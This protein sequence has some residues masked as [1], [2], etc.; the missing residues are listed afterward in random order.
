[1]MGSEATAQ[2]LGNGDLLNC[3]L[4]CI[5]D[6]CRSDDCANS[7]HEYPSKDADDPCVHDQMLARFLSVSKQWF[8][9]AVPYHW[10]EA[11][12]TKLCVLIQASRE[13]GVSDMLQFNFRNPPT[14]NVGHLSVCNTIDS[15]KVAALFGVRA[16]DNHEWLPERAVLSPRVRR[17]FTT[18]DRAAW[19][20]STWR[21]HPTQC[22]HHAI[23][24]S[25][26]QHA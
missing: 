23:R 25:V 2:A 16:H 6:Q 21:E 24:S 22:A 3:I 18:D 13:N 10:K 1:M 20:D 15:E 8:H 12:I 9:L 14:Y 19:I 11:D 4:D 17:A 5:A 26:V 7:S